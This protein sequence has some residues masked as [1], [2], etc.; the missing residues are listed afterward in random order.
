MFAVRFWVKTLMNKAMNSR[1]RFS[2]VRKVCS[3]WRISVM[4]KI[5]SLRKMLPPYLICAVRR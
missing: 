3:A 4:M 1:F 5:G 2:S